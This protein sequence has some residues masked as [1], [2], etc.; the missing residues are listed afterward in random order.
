MSTIVNGAV[1]GS[2]TVVSDI[3]NP[4]PSLKLTNSTGAT[5]GIFVWDVAINLHVST[6]EALSGNFTLGLDVRSGPGD[7]GNGT[8]VGLA[9]RQG[10]DTYYE[11]MG[12]TD[13][14]GAAFRTLN[15][16][17]TFVAGQFVHLVGSGNATPDFSGGTT[18]FPGL[19]GYNSR[20]NGTLTEYYDNYNLNYSAATPEPSTLLLFGGGFFA[21]GILRARCQRA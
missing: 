9:V 18:T 10:S 12:T 11:A 7:F 16:N 17:G 1:S 13:N 6:A 2:I 14:P 8:S 20:I 15:F 19:V 5:N 4:V 21:I 3:G